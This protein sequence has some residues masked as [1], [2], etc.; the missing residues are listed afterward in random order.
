MLKYQEA[1]LVPNKFKT[2]RVLKSILLYYSSEL[3][4]KFK[5]TKKHK[6]VEKHDRHKDNQRKSRNNKRIL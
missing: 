1:V 6:E 5:Y 4:K 2:L 3:L